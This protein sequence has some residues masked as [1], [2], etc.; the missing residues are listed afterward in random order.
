MAIVFVKGAQKL[1]TNKKCDAIQ[2][3]AASL[4]I[5]F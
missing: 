3:K 4:A 1:Q 5:L 2:Q